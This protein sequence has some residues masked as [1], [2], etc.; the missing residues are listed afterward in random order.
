VERVVVDQ[1]GLRAEEADLHEC[2]GKPP[3][4]RLVEE[5]HGG[6][7][8]VLALGEVELGEQRG[9]GHRQIG[10]VEPATVGRAF[11]KPSQLR[12]RQLLRSDARNRYAIPGAAER[13]SRKRSSAAPLSSCSVVPL[14]T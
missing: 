8:Q 9:V 1:I 2:A 4:G 3:L 11:A 7:L 6:P 12:S 14:R 10:R 5:E 13:R